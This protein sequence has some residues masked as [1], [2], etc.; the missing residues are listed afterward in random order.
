M[1]TLLGAFAGVLLTATLV[2]H[3]ATTTPTS[4]LKA[5]FTK[6]QAATGA[7]VYKANCAMCHGDKLSNGG[8]PK[9][10]GSVFLTK[11]ATNTL[12]DFHYIMSTTMPQTAPGTLK[13][14]EY[15][16]VTTY[17]LQQNGA[18]PGKAAFKADDLKKYGFKK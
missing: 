18:K 11:W 8:A 2:A 6:E 10:A 14:A 4:Y 1:K 3:A 5:P 15:L 16:A 9:L 13:P 7:K 17:I 12:D